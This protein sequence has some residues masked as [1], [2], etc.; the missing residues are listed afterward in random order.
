MYG[1]GT[2]KIFGY[3]VVVNNGL[4]IE[5]YAPGDKLMKNPLHPHQREAGKTYDSHRAGRWGAV[6][7]LSLPMLREGMRRGFYKVM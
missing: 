1:D 4:V 3:M 6:A 5:A 2:Y 7:N